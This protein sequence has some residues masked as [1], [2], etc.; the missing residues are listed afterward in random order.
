ML[1]IGLLSLAA[2]T[3]LGRLTSPAFPTDFLQ[4]FLDGVGLACVIRYLL[5]LR[6]GRLGQS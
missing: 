5:A 4:G 3:V 2:A 1:L 6:T